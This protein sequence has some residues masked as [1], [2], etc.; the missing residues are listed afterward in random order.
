M[1]EGGPGERRRRPAPSA[2][3]K[4]TTRGLSQGH[5]RRWSLSLHQRSHPARVVV[6]AG[7]L[8]HTSAHKGSPLFRR[9]AP[10]PSTVDPKGLRTARAA[11]SSRQGVR[12]PL[13]MDGRDAD[14]RSRGRRFGE[15]SP[16]RPAGRCWSVG[17]RTPMQ[18]G[19]RAGGSR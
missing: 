7:N 11:G 2:R 9:R 10:A 8:W 17:T 16:S 13:A 4:E 3:D 15:G 19:T 6:G 14:Q 18:K 12:R 1:G 5:G